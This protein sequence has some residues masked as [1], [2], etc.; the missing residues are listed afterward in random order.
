L[1]PEIVEAQQHLDSP[2]LFFEKRLL[3]NPSF[4][5]AHPYEYEIANCEIPTDPELRTLIPPAKMAETEF[6]FVQTEA[7]LDALILELSL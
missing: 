7:E 6:K 1:D 4:E 2:G 5:L 3:E